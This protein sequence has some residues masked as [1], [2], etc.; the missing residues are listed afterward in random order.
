VQFIP[1]SIDP[2]VWQELSTMNSGNPTGD[3]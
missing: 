3:W 1:N 2:G